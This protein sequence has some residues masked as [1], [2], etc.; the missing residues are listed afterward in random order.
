MRLIITLL[1]GFTISLFLAG[2]GGDN[3]QPYDGTWALLYPAIATS[4]GS[5]TCTNLPGTITI[6][7][8]TGTGTGTVTATCTTAAASGVPA[9]TTYPYAIIS[10]SIAAKTDITSKDIFNAIVNGVTFTGQCLSTT[11]CSG[12]DTA[13]ATI[14]INR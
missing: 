7:N 12:A 13:G 6:Q 2:C 4:S 9:T 14:S 3:T 11:A 1:A 8:A 5:A 10:V